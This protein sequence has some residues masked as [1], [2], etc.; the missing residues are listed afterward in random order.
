MKNVDRTRRPRLGGQRRATTVAA[1]GALL[2]F[3]AVLTG[4]PPDSRTPTGPPPVV[5]Q[6]G[7]PAAPDP[8]TLYNAQRCSSVLTAAA[9]NP[10]RYAPNSPFRQP[11][12]CAGVATDSARWSQRWF[13]ASNDPDNAGG[14]DGRGDINLSFNDWSV[15]TYD[16]A[17]YD[18]P[19]LRWVRVFNANHAANGAANT[20]LFP[21]SDEFIPSGKWVNGFYYI[22]DDSQYVVYD[23]RTGQEW[24][25]WK[26]PMNGIDTTVWDPGCLTNRDGSPSGFQIGVDLCVGAAFVAKNPDGSQANLTT[27]TGISNAV[28]TAMGRNFPLAGIITAKEVAR[29]AINHPILLTM[30]SIM[31]GPE[32]S[33]LGSNAVLYGNCVDPIFPATR[34]ENAHPEASCPNQM[35]DVPPSQQQTVPQGMRFALNLSDA[36]INWWLDRRG[37]TGTTRATVEKIVRAM[38]DYG[39]FVAVTGCDG[40]GIMMDGASNPDTKYVWNH[41]LGINT[42]APDASWLLYGLVGSAANVVRLNPPP[43]P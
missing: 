2:A 10:G 35:T 37:Y 30:R 40:T 23:S 24:S 20:T 19:S 33:T 36:E 9:A 32:C 17:D 38:R 42:D 29:G 13:D 27:S 18:A 6:T 7:R 4:C 28:N 8:A 12:A 3:S 43:T 5:D 41:K 25:V 15:P 31:F 16:L 26:Q 14:W 22:D 34:V 21:Y 1:I 39:F 11:A